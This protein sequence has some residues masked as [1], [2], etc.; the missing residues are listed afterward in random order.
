VMRRFTHP[1]AS[2]IVGRPPRKQ[3]RTEVPA[4][5]LKYQEHQNASAPSHYA[6]CDE[7]YKRPYIANDGHGVV[8]KY[9]QRFSLAPWPNSSSLTCRFAHDTGRAATWQGRTSRAN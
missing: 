6:S 7:L 5:R 2:Q 4:A 1:C 9:V 8:F 3:G